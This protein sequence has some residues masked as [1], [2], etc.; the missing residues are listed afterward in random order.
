VGGVGQGEKPLLKEL[1]FFNN[2]V[3][4]EGIKFYA[5]GDD[6]FLVCS[7]QP[8]R[9]LGS[10]VLGGDLRWA[11]YIINHTVDKDYS[12]N[13][14]YELM[15]VANILRLEK[16]VVGM[17]TAVSITNTVL[18]RGNTGDLQVA[19]FCTAG[20]GNPGIAG[21][22]ALEGKEIYQPGTINI[23]LLIDGNLTDAAMVNAVIT[24]TEA[25]TRA[26]YKAKIVTAGGELITGT[27][28]DAMVV[29][30]TGRGKLINYAGTA[31]ELGY[32]VG[33]TVF[34]ALLQ[35]IENYLLITGKIKMVLGMFN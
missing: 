20:I 14:G 26:F 11:R 31:T 7:S 3:I 23:I 15:K 17:M 25:K 5:H 27:T 32:L 21:K 35:G 29:A 8:L 10:A 9:V 19:A 12:G 1:E 4:I 6:T 24:A 30:C 18:S 13:P 34:K 22:A 2:K 33:R 16:D 28:T